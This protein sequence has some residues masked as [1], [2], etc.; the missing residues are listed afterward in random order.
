MGFFC[1]LIQKRAFYLLT[2][3][4][5]PCKL[6]Q[7]ISPGAEGTCLTESGMLHVACMSSAKGLA[8]FPISVLYKVL[9]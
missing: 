3:E 8:T 6:S 1:E 9:Q 2:Q 4:K 7:L 5:V